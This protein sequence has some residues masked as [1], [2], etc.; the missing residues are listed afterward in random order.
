MSNRHIVGKCTTH[1]DRPAVL[2]RLV[3]GK[4]HTSM[5]LCADC[6]KKQG[7]RLPYSR[8]RSNSDKNKTEAYWQKEKNGLRHRND[9]GSGYSMDDQ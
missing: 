5:F 3:L 1:P 4:P 6:A 9:I 8:W 7:K 2:E